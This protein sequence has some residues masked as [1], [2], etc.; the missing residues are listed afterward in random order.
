VKVL[1]VYPEFPDT[2]WSFKHALKF[3]KKKSSAPPLGLLTVGALL[4][5]DWEKRLVD[6]NVR[7][8]TNKDIRWADM[9]LISGMTVQREPAKRIIQRCKGEG[10]PIVAGGPLFTMEPDSFPDVDHLILNEAEITLPLFLNDLAGGNPRRV[11]ETT[12]FPNLKETP[13]PLWSMLEL[14]RYDTM[15]IQFSRGCPFNCDFCNVTALLGHRP[16]IK[17]AEQILVELDGLYEIGWRGSVFFVDDN[18]IG[19]RRYLKDELLP[20]LSR[21]RKGKSGFSFHTEAS[22]NLADDKELIQLMTNAGFSKVFIGIETPDETSLVECNKGQNTNRD[23]VQDVKLL[24]RSGLEVQGGFIVGFDSDNQSIFQR[25]IDFIQNSGIVTAMVGLLQAPPGTKLYE[26][27]K[28][29]NRIAGDMSGDNVDGSTN[30]IPRMGL[31]K[32]RSGYRYLMEQIYAPQQFY[33]RVKIF[34]REYQPPKIN[35]PISWQEFLAFFRSIYHLG[36]LN[37][38]R[39]HFWDLLFWTLKERP[40]LFPTAVTMAIYGYHFNKICELHI[41]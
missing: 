6:L 34:L 12:E 7:S 39:R 29:E 17:H 27:L 8:L 10:V 1:L 22:I 24:Q 30:I 40:A 23:L 35:S 21:W 32:L 15:P 26:R 2:F 38:E 11:Y 4:P 5:K 37:K 28:R 18:F 19:N 14:N 31:D 33:Q 13:S 20:A 41:F 16:R 25:Q 36:I 3:I 9:V